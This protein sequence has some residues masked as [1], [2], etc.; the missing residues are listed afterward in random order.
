MIGKERTRKHGSIPSRNFLFTDRP[1]MTPGDRT[2]SQLTSNRRYISQCVKLTTQL[3]LVPGSTTALLLPP[4][5]PL[6]L[7]LLLW[8]YNS[9][10][11][12]NNILPFKAILDLSCS[13]YNFHLFQVIPDVIF[14]SALGPSYKSS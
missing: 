2:T 4:P 12:L 8:H 13:F 6:L 10:G 7:L 11:L 14:P 5:S 9:L 3:H 1:I